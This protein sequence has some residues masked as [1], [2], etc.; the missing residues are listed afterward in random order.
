MFTPLFC[1]DSIA[2]SGRH[3]TCITLAL[4]PLVSPTFVKGLPDRWTAARCPRPRGDPVRAPGPRRPGRALPRPEHDRVRRDDRH[5]HS[6][7]RLPVRA[8]HARRSHQRRERFQPLRGPRRRAAGDTGHGV[9]SGRGGRR[10][11]GGCLRDA[12]TQRTT[13]EKRERDGTGDTAPQR[14]TGGGTG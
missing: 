2:W 6:G 5:H 3:A 9:T 1:I 12:E 4:L 10:R 11:D 7:G 13:G 14:G 8:G